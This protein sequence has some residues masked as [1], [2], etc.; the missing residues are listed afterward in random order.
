M[1]YMI[2]LLMEG[3]SRKAMAFLRS[4][5]FYNMSNIVNISRIVQI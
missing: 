2:D 4:E 1:I 5:H 3:H